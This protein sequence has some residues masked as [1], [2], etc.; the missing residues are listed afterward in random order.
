MALLRPATYYIVSHG[1]MSRREGLLA[2]YLVKG[3]AST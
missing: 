2:E 1:L 3:Q